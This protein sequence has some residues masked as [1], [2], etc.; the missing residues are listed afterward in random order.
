MNMLRF[1]ISY[2]EG[3]QVILLVRMV[4]MK[5][6]QSDWIMV[7]GKLRNVWV[8]VVGLEIEIGW[9]MFLLMGWIRVSF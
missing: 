9:W 5:E 4:M 8:E 7:D 6:Y 1:F 3:N 2:L